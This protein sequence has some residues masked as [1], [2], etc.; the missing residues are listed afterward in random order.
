MD[1][2]LGKIGHRMLLY[3]GMLDSAYK[4]GIWCFGKGNRVS[5]FESSSEHKE[6]IQTFMEI[7]GTMDYIYKNQEVY[8]PIFFTD[9]LG[10]VWVGEWVG[11]TN[12]E[13]ANLLFLLGPVL[14]GANTLRNLE[15][16]LQ[17]LHYSKLVRDSLLKVLQSLPV[18]EP[19][20]FMSLGVMLHY[21]LYGEEVSMSECIFQSERTVG[22]SEEDDERQAEYENGTQVTEAL[23][24][25]VVR[26]GDTEGAKQYKYF[27][28]PME[29]S[30][31]DPM[32][33]AQNTLIVFTA[34]CSRAAIEGG[35]PVRTAKNLEKHYISAVESTRMPTALTDLSNTMF[36]DFTQ[37]VHA[38]REGPKLSRP[39]ADCCAYIQGHLLGDLDLKTIAGEIGYSEYYLTKKFASEMGMRLN[40]YIKQQRIEHAKI[41]LRTT[42]K[43]VQEVSDLLR[44]GSRNYF[45]AVFQSIEGVTPAAY[46]AEHT[47][48]GGETC[49]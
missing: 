7:S 47:T 18:V 39:I 17:K 4:I 14:Y 45:S 24:M 44:F 20:T 23:L 27:G 33:E 21:L 34:L 35:L 38:V 42:D 30:I 31:H 9:A 43:S 19:S 41:L 16:V 40:D 2:P 46:R 25:R 15:Q 12:E 26:E 32:R 10:C 49:T 11:E 8:R 29:L 13:I 3:S 36:L 28:K 6:T 5:L 37:R 22:R 1:E 48:T